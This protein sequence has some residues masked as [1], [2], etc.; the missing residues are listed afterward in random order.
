MTQYLKDPH[1][2]LWGSIKLERVTGSVARTLARPSRAG[3]S[4]FPAHTEQMAEAPRKA[5]GTSAI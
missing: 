1:E 4:R 2:K 5:C 3:S